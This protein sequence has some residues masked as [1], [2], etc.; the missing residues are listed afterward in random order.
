[1]VAFALAIYAGYLH[2]QVW[3]ARGVNGFLTAYNGLLRDAADI[4]CVQKNSVI[5]IAKRNE[6]RIDNNI[7]KW[8][9]DFGQSQ[10][11]IDDLENEPHSIRIY[12]NPEM[13]FSKEPGIVFRFNSRECLEVRR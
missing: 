6:W 5:E 8:R 7:H 3:D 13:P 10:E 1:M 11:Y 2:L 9:L 4:S 12:I